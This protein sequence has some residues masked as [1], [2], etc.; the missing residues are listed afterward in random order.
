MFIQLAFS[1]G[2]H[3][4]AIKLAQMPQQFAFNMNIGSVV[5]C[6][7]DLIKHKVMSKYA[8]VKV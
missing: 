1:L 5:K 4:R 6:K 8:E 3:I 7:V 2:L